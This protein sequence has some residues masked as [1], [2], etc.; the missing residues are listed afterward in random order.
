MPNINIATV[1]N[2][3]KIHRRNTHIHK[4]NGLNIL[5]FH[6]LPTNNYCVEFVIISTL[7]FNIIA[8]TIL[9]YTMNSK[10]D[11]DY[12]IVLFYL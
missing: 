9:P 12:D 4:D 6:I 3:Y 11:R 7:C 2:D 8:L 5:R 10:Q 1:F